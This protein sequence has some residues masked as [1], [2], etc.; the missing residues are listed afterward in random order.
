MSKLPAYVVKFRLAILLQKLFMG[1]STSPKGW[2]FSFGRDHAVGRAL[3]GCTAVA[4]AHFM[5]RAF[6]HSIVAVGKGVQ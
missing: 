4:V 1:S 2:R 5:G 6:V 3:T